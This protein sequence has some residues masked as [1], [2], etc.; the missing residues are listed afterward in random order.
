MNARRQ[1]HRKSCLEIGGVEHE[2][3]APGLKLIRRGLLSNVYWACD[4]SEEFKGYRPRTVRIHVDLSVA[5]PHEV[6]AVIATVEEICNREQQAM[7]AWA[8]G[9]I[10]D[11]QRL[12]PKYDG[13]L[14]SLID[15]YKSDKEL[16][17]Q[18]L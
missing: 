8:D 1:R 7:L 11:K 14:R 3:D 6:A 17:Y 10:D 16:S 15:L 4:E 18:R 9:N 12:G 13:T 5:D 2:L